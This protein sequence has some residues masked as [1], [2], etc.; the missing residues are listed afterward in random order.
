MRRARVLL[1]VALLL[2]AGALAGGAPGAKGTHEQLASTRAL[3]GNITGPDVF[4][5][6]SNKDLFINGTGGPAFAAN[7]TRIGNLTYYASLTGANTTGSLLSPSESGIVNASGAQVLLTVGNISEILTVV[8]ELTSTYQ[9]ANE[10]FNM[11]FDVHV[12]QPYTLSMTLVDPGSSTILAFALTVD[13]DGA[14][15]GSVSIPTLTSKESYVA[16]FQ[17]ATL[18]LSTGSHT[19]SVS[20][21]NEHGLLTFAGGGTTYTKTF[22]IPGPPPNYDLWYIAGT[23][24]FIGALFIFVTRLAARRRAPTRK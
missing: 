1:F 10:S 6:N 23:V 4:G 16:T 18:G 24:A 12:V 13:L 17:Y 2:V 21:A 9:T 5:Y 22:Y 20:L 7:G 3:T 15:V 14:P 8:V 11:T 19:F